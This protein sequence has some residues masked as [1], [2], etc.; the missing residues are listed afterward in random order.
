[1]MEES[2]NSLSDIDEECCPPVICSA[3]KEDMD[4]AETQHDAVLTNTPSSSASASSSAT[5]T[6]N[7]LKPG[8]LHIEEIE[9]LDEIEETEQIT[10]PLMMASIDQSK[11]TLSRRR[12]VSNNDRSLSPH[13]NASSLQ[14]SPNHFYNKRKKNMNECCHRA[15]EIQKNVWRNTITLMNFMAKVLFWVSLIAMSAGIVYYTR[16][17]AING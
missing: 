9:P 13:H 2:A 6:P 12:T 11:R 14:L 15:L 5:T 4:H 16:E 8:P 1:M 3:Q 17:L 10:A 7:K